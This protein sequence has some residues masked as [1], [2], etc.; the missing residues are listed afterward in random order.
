MMRS[1]FFLLFAVS[2][3]GAK[4]EFEALNI[5]KSLQKEI[6]T[7]WSYRESSN[8]DLQKLY[9]ME[10]PFL[11]FL[12]TK[13]EY[14]AFAPPLDFTKIEFDKIFKNKNGK[15]EL[16]GWIVDTDDEKHYFHDLWIKMDGTWYH[17][18]SDKL[19]PF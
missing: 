8:Y 13:M 19:L 18:V 12:Y 17:R 15:I 11:K 7:Y 5:E 3:F 1:F 14:R 2:L 6:Q 10:L 9:N 16:G 4:V